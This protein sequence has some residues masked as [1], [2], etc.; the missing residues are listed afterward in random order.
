MLGMHD[1]HVCVCMFE[2]VYLCL[3]VFEKKYIHT[4]I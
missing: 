3:S 4:Y 1:Q 2:C